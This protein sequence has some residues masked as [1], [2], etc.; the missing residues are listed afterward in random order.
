MK[1]V[2][3]KYVDFWPD[4]KPEEDMIY[5][6]LAESQDYD[7]KLS[8]EPDYLIYSCFGY[9]HLNYEC[10]RIFFTGEEVCPDFNVCDYAAGFEYMSFE[11]RYFRL[12]LMYIPRYR[13]DYYAMLNRPEELDPQ[14]GF[15]S[16]VY[17]N[18]EADPFRTEFFLELSK[19]KKIASGG[20]VFNNTGSPVKDKR[21]FESDYKFS[22]AFENVRH[23]GYTTEK[24]MQAFAAGGVPLYWGDPYVVK[25][26][27]P[28]SFINISDFKNVE[29][30]IEYIKKIDND[31]EAYMAMLSEPAIREEYCLDLIKERFRA[32]IGNIF[33]QDPESAKR[34]TREMFNRK[35]VDLMR[36]REKLCSLS[37]PV[38][39]A[40]GIM[41]SLIKK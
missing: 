24:L 11:D 22:I 8:D 17:S 26:F 14:R 41:R 1:T 33:D 3:I 7:V 6:I 15:C 28:K 27:N 34:T 25:M 23:R 5:E 37:A 39:K 21:L 2:K 32:F 30:A 4:F 10:I 29:E 16:F 12:P 35:Y 19:Y 9:E 20:K 40:A 38:R 13:N 18:P 31:N 36:K